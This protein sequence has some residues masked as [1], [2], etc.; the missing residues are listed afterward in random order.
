M[1]ETSFYFHI[2]L[3]QLNVHATGKLSSVLDVVGVINKCKCVCLQSDIH[4]SS[5]D[6]IIYTPGI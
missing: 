5:G 6:F 1:Y 4:L 3:L 2:F